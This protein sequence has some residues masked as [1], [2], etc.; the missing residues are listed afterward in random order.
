MYPIQAPL[1]DQVIPEKLLLFNIFDKTVKGKPINMSQ[2]QFLSY[3]L[4]SKDRLLV[5]DNYVIL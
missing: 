3:T 2:E 5:S 4:F 1:F